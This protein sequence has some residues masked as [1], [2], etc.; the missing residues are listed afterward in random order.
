MKKFLIL[1][2][3]S[4]SILEYNGIVA[5]QRFEKWLDDDHFLMSKIEGT[6]ERIV[7]VALPAG[8][9]HPFGQSSDRTPDFD[10]KL[11]IGDGSIIQMHS[12]NLHL[13][14][15]DGTERQ[16]TH[17]PYEEKNATLSFDKQKVA[18]TKNHDLYIY[19]LGEN[20]E[21]RLTYNGSKKI[22]NGWASWVYYEEILGR[23][24]NYAAFWWS[25]DSRKLA[26]LHFDDTPV[27]E[28]SLFRSDGQH[29][30]IEK[31]HYPKAGDPNPQTHFLVADVVTGQL[32]RIEEDST[33]DQYTTLPFWSPDSRYLLIQELNRGQDTLRIVRADPNNGTRKIIYE[34]VQE[35]WVDFFEKIEF[36][37]DGQIL[38]RSQRDGWFNL[39]SQDIDGLSLTHLTPV[40]WRVFET[41]AI[42]ADK[43]QIYFYGSGPVSTDRHL[44]S[45]QT[46]GKHFKQI[47]SAPGWHHVI[48]SPDK[49]HFYDEYS[50]LISA[51]RSQIL[52]SQGNTIFSFHHQ[53]DN[54]NKQ[55]GVLVENLTIKTE[56]GLNLPGYWVLPKGF[57]KGRKYPCVFTTYGGPGSDK[58]RNMYRDFTR[59]FF[60]NN[61]II[62]IEVEHRGSGKLGKRGMDYMHRSL[63]KWEVDDLISAVKWLRTLPFVDSTKIGITGSS[64]GGYVTCM[65]LTHGTGFFTHGISLYPVTDWL[66]YDNVYTERYMDHPH[67][68][69]DGYQ[70]GSAVDQ[71]YKLKGELLIVHGMMDDNVHVQHTMQFV[72]KLQDLGKEFEL[73]VYPGERHGWGGAKSSHL[74]RLITSFWKKHFA[75]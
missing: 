8:R 37:N 21:K 67:E 75:D 42:D 2:F 48:P 38:L 6:R 68:N 28:F 41:V 30:S 46:D 31:R 10:Y 59:D 62:R 25:P 18:Y 44:Y 43:G 73:M 5:Q 11:A 47:T 49:T 1:L 29:G 39:Y 9:E 35:T 34:E 55:A 4:V 69:P 12:G 58:M 74:S 15:A 24:S 26:F 65:A 32:I 63:G 36:L 52:D 3:I 40:P 16:L 60:A 51:P 66:L 23:S 71:A 53:E 56:D 20:V 50:S 33:K 72:S 19:D 70:Y 14:F 22:Y 45:V 13:I 57:E 54:I 17:D 27:P 7:K 64:Y 61:D